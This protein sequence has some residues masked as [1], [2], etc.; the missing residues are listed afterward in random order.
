MAIL[1]S[2]RTRFAGSPRGGSGGIVPKGR[3]GETRERDFGRTGHHA[4]ID[5]ILPAGVA[6][7]EAFHDLPDAPLYPEELERVAR[8]IPRR[9]NEYTTARHCARQALGALGIAPVA[10]PT[11][12]RG[13]PRWPTGIV[14]TITHCRGYRAAAVARSA[15]LAAIGID[16]EP[17]EPLPDGVLPS[18]ALPQEHDHLAELFGTN[19][20]TC[21]GR[22][23]FC[24]KEAVYKAWYPLTQRWLGFSEALITFDPAPAPQRARPGH[25]CPE[26]WLG[27]FSAQLIVPTTALDGREL[28]GFEGR[29]L[30]DRGLVLTMVAV[31][32]HADRE[33]P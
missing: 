5:E 11:G 7:S 2:Y 28:S 1:T 4:V 18:I 10:I 21:W 20:D 6:C 33:R 9:R 30:I 32:A 26:R 24:A 13:A 8:A 25:P 31:T 23:L 16:A 27:K 3:R 22:L 19:P 15:D 12:P 14:G 17:H 29:W